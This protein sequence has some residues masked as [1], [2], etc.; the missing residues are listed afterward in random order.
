MCVCVCVCV[1][2]KESERVE[3]GQKGGRERI[4][5]TVSRDPD[6]GLDPRNHKIMT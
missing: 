6:A 2:L 1:C 5:S 3:E 4:P